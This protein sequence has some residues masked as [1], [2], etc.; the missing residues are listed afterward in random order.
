MFIDLFHLLELSIMQNMGA[1]CR[2]GKAQHA[3]WAHLACE[4]G[5]V[6]ATKEEPIRIKRD[7]LSKGPSSSGPI[8]RQ[9]PDQRAEFLMTSGRRQSLNDQR[10]KFHDRIRRQAPQS[11]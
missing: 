9:A 3:T 6:D 2:Y 8:R 1:A 7:S 10:A 11:S 4:Q 5:A